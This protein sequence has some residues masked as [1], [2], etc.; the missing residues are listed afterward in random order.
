M[1]PDGRLVTPEK[2]RYEGHGALDRHR[3]NCVQYGTWNQE[4][5]L[6]QGKGMENPESFS[7]YIFPMFWSLK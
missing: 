6:P 2:D 7:L 3:Q 4:Q 5:L 1:A